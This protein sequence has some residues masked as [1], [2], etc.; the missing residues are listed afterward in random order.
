MLSLKA[1]VQLYL[2][3]GDREVVILNTGHY[4]ST[5]T[6]DEFSGREYHHWIW[7]V[8]ALETSRSHP[9]HPASKGL[10]RQSPGDPARGKVPMVFEAK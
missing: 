9:K 1:V 6:A 5:F 4:G 7:V 3:L 2:E 10:V 8:I